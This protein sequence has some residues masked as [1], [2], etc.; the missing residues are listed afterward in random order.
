MVNIR[1]LIDGVNLPYQNAKLLKSLGNQLHQALLPHKIYGQFQAAI[2]TRRKNR[3]SQFVQS[4]ANL[5]P[6]EEENLNHFLVFS[7]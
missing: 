3:N 4:S 6:R 7:R 2:L 1:R 5:F